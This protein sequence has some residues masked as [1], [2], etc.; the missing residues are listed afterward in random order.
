MLVRTPYTAP[1]DKILEATTLLD[2]AKKYDLTKPTGNFFYDPWVL[3]D[4]FKNTPWECIWKSLPVDTGQARV[5]VLQGGTGYYQH[6]DIDDRY[7]LNLKGDSAYL[8]DLENEVMHKCVSDGIWYEMDAGRIHS[9]ASFGK[10]NRVQLVVR[11]LLKQSKLKKPINIVITAIG[12]KFRYE[13]DNT[14]SP[15]LNRANKRQIINN[16]ERTD[17]SICFELEEDYLRELR[18]VTPVEFKLQWK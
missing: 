9:A 5:I 17:N 4:E 16:F 11:K 14:L 15:W 13:F 2:E 1:A 3:K 12:E 6:A 10:H 8:I 7:H 18:T